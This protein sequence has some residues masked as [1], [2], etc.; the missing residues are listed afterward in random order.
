MRS[1]LHVSIALLALLSSACMSTYRHPEGAPFAKVQVSK[2]GT[3]WLCNGGARLRLRADEAGL[4]TIPTG[5]R[6]TVGLN[7]VASGYN[8]T[9]SCFPF[10][11]VLPA[12][13][14]IYLQDF[15]TEDEKC[16]AI[17]YRKT[18]D[19][20][21]GLAMEPTLDSSGNCVF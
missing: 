20:R 15:E 9:Y 3:P 12:E 19:Q 21:I 14:M 13:N 2:A 6:I 17:L 5:K 1:L 16:S 10:V 8:V 11:S 18:D 7:Y 4:A